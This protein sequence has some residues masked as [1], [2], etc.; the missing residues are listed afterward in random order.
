MKNRLFNRMHA[1][2]EGM[3]DAYYWPV[4]YA[5]DDTYESSKR[6]IISFECNPKCIKTVRNESE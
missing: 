2:N 6:Q 5:I 4:C 1:G 3:L